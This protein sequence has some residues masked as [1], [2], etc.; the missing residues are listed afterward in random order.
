M[1]I[2]TRWE[3]N[4]KLKTKFYIN[5]RQRKGYDADDDATESRTTIISHTLLSYA[6]TVV[7]RQRISIP[8]RWRWQLVYKTMD[9]TTSSM[10]SL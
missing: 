7:T 9:G 2:K 6:S 5:L 10:I 4:F 1:V 3:L 8:T